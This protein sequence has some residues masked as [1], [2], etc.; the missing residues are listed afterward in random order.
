MFDM[1]RMLDRRTRNYNGPCDN[2]GPVKMHA[3]FAFRE[4]RS[5]DEQ[6]DV[7][8]PRSLELALQP[9]PLVLLGPV[10]RL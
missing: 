4:Q 10:Q 7:I 2:E 5:A 3:L 8:R 9:D 1:P 6:G